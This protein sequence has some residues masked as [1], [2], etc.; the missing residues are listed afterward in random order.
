MIIAAIRALSLANLLVLPFWIFV[1]F[2]G[3][4]MDKAFL[5]NRYHHDHGLINEM[6]LVSLGAALL[7]TF[8]LGVFIYLVMTKWRAAVW[9]RRLV[10]GLLVIGAIG[11]LNAIR[12]NYLPSLSMA[13]LLTFERAGPWLILGGVL[14]VGWLMVAMRRHVE[15]QTE[16]ILMG[17]AP[18][19]LM[20]LING[21]WAISLLRLPDSGWISKN[22][23]LQDYRTAPVFDGRRVLIFIFDA[24]DYEETFETP[25]AEIR[26]PEINRLAKGSI[27]LRARP[28]DK[29][30]LRAIPAVVTGR[31]LERVRA[32]SGSDLKVQYA[33]SLDWLRLSQQQTVFDDI[34]ALGGNVA[35][36]GTAYHP[37]CYLFRRAVVSCAGMGYWPHRTRENV[38]SRLD[39]VVQVIVQ[40]YPAVRRLMRRRHIQ[41]HALPAADAYLKNVERIEA[42]L[43]DPRHHL[44]YVHLMMPHGPFIYNSKTDDFMPASLDPKYYPDALELVD[45]TIG[46]IRGAME[47]DGSWSKTLVAF[48]ADHGRDGHIPILLHHPQAGPMPPTGNVTPYGLRA[49]V[50]AYLKGQAP[51]A[52]DTLAFFRVR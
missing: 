11:A 17:L 48:T 40:Q 7:L 12:I 27:L 28:F 35:L 39:D 19:A 9:S 5:L 4:P 41:R 45:R 34:R 24:W 50:S 49:L 47:A 46:R 38:L 8:L 51:S 32:A 26:L 44:V 16:I 52:T 1:A 25:R 31:P 37:L 36:V 14:V 6:G 20:V 29:N 30:T 33:G 2:L 21:V 10:Y 13:G 15:L 42:A 3:T 43:S 22:Y 18:L 23:A